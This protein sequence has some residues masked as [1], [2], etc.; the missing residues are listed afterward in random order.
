M[1]ILNLQEAR[2]PKT[3]TTPSVCIVGNLR[4]DEL[5][6]GEANQAGV[7]QQDRGRFQPHRED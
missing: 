1:G 2:T 3:T 6:R 4:G 7:Q 5:D